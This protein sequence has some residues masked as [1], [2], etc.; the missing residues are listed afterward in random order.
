LL[1]PDWNRDRIGV[2]VDPVLGGQR[3]P[4]LVEVDAGI[5]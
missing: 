1:C 2:R 4:L 3:V 5:T